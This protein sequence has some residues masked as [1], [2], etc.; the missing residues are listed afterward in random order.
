MEHTI[1]IQPVVDKQA[2]GIIVEQEGPRYFVVSASKRLEWLDA[3]HA[4]NSY[5][6][7]HEHVGRDD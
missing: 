4:V 2:K 3:I 6:E 1:R 5:L 7:L